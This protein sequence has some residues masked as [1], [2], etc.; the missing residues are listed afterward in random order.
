MDFSANSGLGSSAFARH[1]WRNRFFFLFLRVLRCFT[2]PS[3]LLYPMYSDIG[4]GALPPLGSPIRKSPDQSLFATPRGLPQLT[5]SFIDFW[6]QGIHRKPLITWPCYFNLF[7][8]ETYF[9]LFLKML[10]LPY[11]V[12][13]EHTITRYNTS[14]LE[15]TFTGGDERA[16]TA[17]LLRARQA[18]SQL[19]Y[20]P[21]LWVKSGK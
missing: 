2:S 3:C 11:L 1:Y 10:L 6:H 16:W 21:G 8:L 18:L 15:W 17:G 4:N 19:S 12:F 7:L 13:K 14:K 20:I 5:T 9:N